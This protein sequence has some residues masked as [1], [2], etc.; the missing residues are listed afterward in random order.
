MRMHPPAIATWLLKHLGCSSDNDAVLGDLSERYQEGKPHAWY[1]K[2][3]LIAIAVSTFEDIR[4]RK[5]LA[6]RAV[7][8]GCFVQLSFEVLMTRYFPLVPYWVPLSWWGTKFEY[9]IS[10][11]IALLLGIAGGW[12]I[13]RLY[14]R[15]RAILLFYLLIMQSLGALTIAISGISLAF[16]L[17]ANGS[18]ALGILVGGFWINRPVRASDLPEGD[19]Q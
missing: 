1:W 12:T 5:L 16:Y 19:I 8:A 4:S 15:R 7:L 2:Q 17:T 9:M 14:K 18:L 13:V 6:L 11:A 10:S 3:T